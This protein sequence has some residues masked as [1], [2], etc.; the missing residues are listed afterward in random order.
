MTIL[1]TGATGLVGRELTRQL[2]ARGHRLV[3]LTRSVARA[4]TRLGELHTYV[5]WD[6]ASP[7][8]Q[9]AYDGVDVIINLMGEGIAD[10]RWTP[11]QKKVIQDSRIKATSAL[12][13]G[14][15]TY[16]PHLQVMISSSAVGI[17]DHRI[18]PLSEDSP[19]GQDF[20]AE[21]CQDWE[22][23][24]VAIRTLPQVREVRIRTGVVLSKDGG[25]LSKMSRPFLM[26]LGGKIGSGTQWMNWIHIDDL[27]RIFVSAL[28]DCKYAGPINAVAPDNVTN[29][30]FSAQL[31]S[32]LSRPCLVTVP[33]FVL[34][35]ALGEMATILTQGG[36]VL[37]T[38][39]DRL[40]F[41]FLFPQLREA[42]ENCL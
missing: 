36:K 37:P 3:I 5:S 42:L 27:V 31:A 1:L 7:L 29:A 21:V 13:V 28:D 4:K 2:M 33:E 41:Q 15:I 17:Y 11:T 34:K 14:A 10:K 32:A 40:G 18:S 20:L 24:A 6:G 8:P 19:F 9:H 16:A 22:D 30:V 35:L 38:A 12:V 39:L 23:S 25:A 26:G